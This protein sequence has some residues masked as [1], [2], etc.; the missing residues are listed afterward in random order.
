MLKGAVQMIHGRGTQGILQEFCQIFETSLEDEK[1]KTHKTHNRS[2]LRPRGNMWKLVYTFAARFEE[3]N[4]V[5]SAKLRNFEISLSCMEHN[6]K[7]WPLQTFMHIHL[8]T[9]NIQER[10][11]NKCVVS[12]KELSLSFKFC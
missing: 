3:L 8:W 1:W 6:L 5:V 4:Q 7:R 12:Y 9:N 2:V 11:T 10:I